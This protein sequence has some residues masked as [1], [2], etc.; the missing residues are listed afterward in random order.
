MAI[1]SNVNPNYPI[2]GLD[3]SSKGFRDNFATIKQEIESIQSTTIQLAGGVISEPYLLGS[4]DS[5]VIQTAVSGT[6]VALAP[7]NYAIQ[8][9][10]NSVLTGNV[11]LVY[12]SGNV[13]VGIGTSR[14]DP[15]ASIDAEK[16]IHATNRVLVQQHMPASPST[17]ELHTFSS[18]FPISAYDDHVTFGGGANIWMDFLTNSTVALHVNNT[19]GIGIGTTTP[20]GIIH[21]VT[22][23]Q[24]IGR[25]VTSSPQS[26]NLLRLSTLDLL[27]TVGIG[28]EHYSGNQLGGMSIDSGGILGFHTGE[29]ANSSLSIGSTRMTIDTS[30][31]VGIGNYYPS[32]T[33]DV[34]GTFS[35]KGITDS[36]GTDYT[37][38]QIGQPYQGYTGITAEFNIFGDT[39]STGATI[40]TGKVI[41]VD[42]TTLAI[43]TWPTADFRSAKYTIQVIN[44]ASGIESVDLIECIT[45]H[46]N[47]NP[48]IYTTSSHSTGSSLGTLNVSIS[49][50]YFS[51]NYTGN[52][53]SNTIKLSRTYM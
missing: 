53:I 45:T 12:D 13:S 22:N 17:V 23:R 1:G 14:P 25:L 41:V 29:N 27:S 10:K 5:L 43:D 15:S 31:S 8:F 51:L 21:G 49:N 7:P 35:S 47:G 40:L 32:Y 37:S 28:L 42:T 6:A 20:A 34:N 11:N 36:S 2:P 30:G 52:N 9:N 18:T 26:F 24:E 3:Q 38:V 46:A 16:E 44:S 50:N 19:G 39:V 33:L 4:A 48:Y